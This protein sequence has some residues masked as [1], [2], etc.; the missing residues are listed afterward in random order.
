M[1]SNGSWRV[2]HK[3][4]KEP[5]RQRLASHHVAISILLVVAIRAMLTITVAIVILVHTVSI[6]SPVV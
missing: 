3:N 5:S 6:K 4:K 2:G 1:K